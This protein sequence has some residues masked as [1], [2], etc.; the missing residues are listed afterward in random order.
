MK[1]FIFGIV[2]AGLLWLPAHAAQ[3]P[4]QWTLTLDQKSAP[5]GGK[6]LAKLTGSIE[7]G[8]H[9]YSLTTPSGGPNATTVTLAENPAVAAVHIYQ[10]KPERKF[11]PNFQL[12]TETFEKSL[13]LLLEIDLKPD[14]SA[15]STDLTAQVRYQCCTDKICLPP[16]RKTATA[17]LTIDASAKSGTISI[18]PGYTEVSANTPA[19]AS[20]AAGPAIPPAPQAAADSQ[21]LFQFLLVAFGFGLAEIFTPCVF[22]MIP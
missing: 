20:A 2:V 17:A 5:P 19:R 18:P 11:D 16:K 13:T 9:L 4:V 12:E 15:G 8:W 7:S 6:V 3:D 21:G 22:P 1:R 14:A 10:P